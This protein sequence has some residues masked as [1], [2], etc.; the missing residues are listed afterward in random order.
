[1]S[2]ER[3]ITSFEILTMVLLK[4]KVFWYVMPC[5]LVSSHQYFKG[6]FC[7][8]LQSQAV[9]SKD[10]TTLIFWK[11]SNYLPTDMVC[12]LRGLKS[13]ITVC[14]IK[15]PDN[16]RTGSCVEPANFF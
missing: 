16:D 14:N 8:H 1:M 10:E 5:Q 11:V 9:Q 4:N 7:L 3:E 13:S 2:L 15:H 12:H 6:F